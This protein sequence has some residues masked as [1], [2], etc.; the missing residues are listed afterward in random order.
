M[1]A[2]ASWGVRRREHVRGRGAAIVGTSGD[3]P[4]PASEKAQGKVPKPRGNS[5]MNTESM[6]RLKMRG[7]SRVAHL[8]IHILY[9]YVELRSR[10]AI[11]RARACAAVL[12]M[13]A[14]A[15]TGV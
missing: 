10:V 12:R 2:R 15:V 1:G 7:H 13:R 14:A 5:E 3:L 4:S 8:H 9:I 11:G 6:V